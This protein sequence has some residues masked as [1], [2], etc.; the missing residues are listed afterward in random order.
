MSD[1]MKKNLSININTNVDTESIKK[2]KSEIE[3]FRQECERD[4][5][6]LGI[7]KK[8][9]KIDTKSFYK[10][11]N[12]A[13]DLDGHLRTVEKN[14]PKM[15]K[16]LD[17]ANSGL[18][19]ANN[20]KEELKDTLVIF[21]DKSLVRG[22][23][24]IVSKISDGFSI[25]T[26]DIG[27]RVQ[28]LK[29]Q[30]SSMMGELDSVDA[31]QKNH[32]GTYGFSG[33][34]MTSGQLEDRIDTLK[35]LAECQKELEV[36]N[37]GK[38]EYEVA[39]TG[40][41][42]AG[43]DSEV[44]QLK[45]N[46]KLLKTYN[47]E[48]TEQL[49]RRRSLIEEA[50]NAW[51]WDEDDH[52]NAKNNI[53]D[54][55]A[56]E[57]AIESLKYYIEQRKSI[58]QQLQNSEYELFSVDGISEYVND[59]NAQISRFESQMKEL[60]DLRSGKSIGTDSGITGDLSEVVSALGRVEEAVNNVVDAFKPLT[61]AL[62]N[63]DSALSAMVNA[64]IADL[65]KL[66]TEVKDTFNNIETLS[67][68]QFNVTN[69][70]SNGNNTNNDI[71]QFR[72]FRKEARDVYK[73]VEELYAESIETSQKI[74]ST[75]G[76][77]SA[78]LDFN[79]SMSDFDLSDL[80]R[81]I[82]SKSSTSLAAVI[83]EL[84][85]W[86]KVLLQFNNLRN[87]VDAGS[88]NVSKY[89]DTSSKVKI[90][91][92]TTDVDEQAIVD[93]AS[94]DNNILDQVKDLSTK[95]QEELTSIRAKIEETFNFSTIDP[96]LAN[97][98]PVVDSIYQQFAEL[99]SKIKA[100]DFSIEIDPIDRETLDVGADGTKASVDGESVAA[101]DADV[102]FAG[103]AASKRAFADANREAAQ[104]AEQTVH[105]AK[106]EADALK[107]VAEQAE[108]SAGKIVDANKKIDKVKYVQ[109]A[110][111]NDISK[112]TTTTAQRENAYETRI[113]NYTY[114]EDGNEELQ[115][116]TI[117][118]DFK[119][120]AA[121]A[122]KVSAKVELAKKAVAKFLSQ[123]NNKTAGHGSDIE[124]YDTLKNFNIETLDDIESAM[125]QMMDLDTKYN[126]LTRDFR[127]GTKSMNPFV[128]AFNSMDEMRNKVKDIQLDFGNL[129]SP[130]DQLR[131]Q[132]E[133]LPGLL[134]ELN[135]ALTPDENGVINI[136]RIAQ[137]YGNLNEAIKQA[138]SSVA[139][140]RKEEGILQSQEKANTKSYDD[141][142]KLQDKL[143]NAKKQLAKV[144]A[145]SAKGLELSRKVEEYQE[146]YD[147]AVELLQTEEQRA[148]VTERQVKLDKELEG[149][150]ER[151]QNNYG[152]TVFNREERYNGNINSRMSLLDG[153]VLNDNFEQKLNKYKEV[154]AELERLRNEFIDNPMAENDLG[155][156]NQF[157][158]AAMQC[159]KLRKEILSTFK[160]YDKFAD[161]PKDS[162]LGE[163]IFDPATMNDTKTA[164]MQLA[165][166]AT[167]GQFKFKGFNAA[168]TE[169]YGVINKG[170][171]VL[172]EVTV[173]FSAATNEMKAFTSGSKQVTTS[174][175]KL[176]SELKS[177]INQIVG[178]YIGFHEALQAVKQG[179]EYVK[180]IDL[181][182]TELK[183]V[184][185]ETDVAYNNFLST[186]SKTAATIGST[187]SD[188]TDAT[189]A[190]A[191]L[192]YSL[193]ESAKMAET[194]II[195]KNVAD[196][197]DSVEESTDS[198]I[199]TMMAYG[200]AADDTMSIIDRFN[201]VG[202]NFAITSAG[203]GEAMQRSASALKE[204]G[205]TIDESI[206]LITAANSVVYIVPR[207]YSNI[208]TS[209]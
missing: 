126:N 163:N 87:D 78:F 121:E 186:A 183:K 40:M 28:Y 124:G 107:Q 176:G 52:S 57:S 208:A 158:Q 182:M 38:F 191:R 132:V 51:Q 29:D 184:T 166:A 142:I 12:A 55:E 67:S 13:K 168:G 189:S 154:Y 33:D 64:S 202:N 151:A 180:A 109:D 174:W 79:N 44:K 105:G 200:I 185:D 48:T 31:I 108:E 8:S 75:P 159:E 114:D 173:R 161:I 134:D 104:T 123:F 17:E 156:Q 54:D 42:S 116:I 131:E 50:Q 148:Q 11:I 76:G 73:Q 150:K 72:Q 56:Y 190:F 130:T 37:G 24:N 170:A 196:G 36:F 193:D 43:I 26:V 201:A 68:K 118:E 32:W 179:V 147:A 15:M 47:L 34:S 117:I 85:E 113:K 139:L 172:E 188:F 207:R 162:V 112:Q 95:V 74:K 129:K 187:V 152:K 16:A 23:D 133:G 53:K 20:F 141:A 61:D 119:K 135:S 149:I 101:K 102:A 160:E 77:I 80:A 71:E 192:G 171:G 94:I 100:L 199:S 209:R 49:N 89:N 35:R 206:A 169:M 146:Q 164:M 194:A 122:E 86:K 144:D 7:D 203:I 157:D 62:A 6:K 181:A 106:A 127:K 125:Q 91:S 205:N 153:Q 82:K 5:I 84:N 70:I 178:Q 140:Q 1:E 83:D 59:A 155:L 45:E 41:T 97:V 128:N 66:Q 39:P 103:A 90:G 10:A 3:A 19:F 198:I 92:K 99:Q 69:V 81:R 65:E 9:L 2:A 4:S 137:A 165:D 14:A 110:N 27:E 177:G 136:E 197:L 30:I 98:Q 204:G 18:K 167:N 143:Y 120:K 46:L 22:F 145:G 115:T 93:N 21:D 138:K 88:F 60:E 96:Q 58:I 175:G 195:Y 111:G 63:Q 25:V